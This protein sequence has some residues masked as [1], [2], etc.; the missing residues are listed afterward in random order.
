MMIVRAL[1]V[2]QIPGL[3]LEKGGGVGPLS[4]SSGPYALVPPRSVGIRCLNL[5]HGPRGGPYYSFMVRVADPTSLKSPDMMAFAGLFVRLYLSYSTTVTAM[6]D[7][8]V[9]T[10]M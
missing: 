6:S 10:G 8:I 4:V 3:G 2:K 5:F 1:D 9:T 7:T